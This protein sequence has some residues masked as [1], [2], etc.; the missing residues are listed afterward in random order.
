MSS[1]PRKWERDMRKDILSILHIP[2]SEDMICSMRNYLPAIPT[3]GLVKCLPAC[4]AIHDIMSK[5]R[6]GD[7]Q[8]FVDKL[9][10]QGYED[11]KLIRT[12]DGK[13]M[14]K[15]EAKRLGLTG[16]TLLVG[17]K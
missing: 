5:N 3:S 10:A 12:D 1:M 15:I 17:K 8:A 2:I 9:K 14:T 11:V 7:M 6:Y 16:S 13:F 4:F